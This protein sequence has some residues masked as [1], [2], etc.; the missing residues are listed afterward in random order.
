MS[1]SDVVI[2]GAGI[3]GVAAAD[4][5]AARGASV[6]LVDERAPLSL[7]S[8]KSTEC[9]RNWWPGPGNA[10]VALMNRSIDLIEALA[11]ATGNAFLLNRRGYLYVTAAPERVALLRQAGEEAA[12]LGA[13]PL[14]V[15]SSSASYAPHPAHGYHNQPDGAD[16]ILDHAT[17]RH[18]F[19]YLAEDTVAVLHARRCGWLSAQQLGMALLERGRSRGVRLA[20]ARVTAVEAT[21]G[22]VTAVTLDDGAQRVATGAFVNAAGPFLRLV[23]QMARIDLPVF[24]ERHRKVAFE[25]YLGAIPRDAPMIIC[26]DPQTLAWSADER[27]MLAED[28]EL[29]HLLGTLPAGVHCRPEGGTGS[30]W[31]LGLWAYDAAPV[32]ETFPLPPAPHF[33]DVVL[34]GLARMIPP[35]SAYT[36]R[37]PR[38]VLDGGYYTRTRENRP[39]IGPAGPRGSFVIGALSGYGIMAACG[40]AELLAAHIAGDALPPYAPACHPARYA[41]AAYRA[42]LDDWPDTGQL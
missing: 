19:P 16:L 21:G 9:Y 32:A 2:C 7:T 36:E 28:D 42:L 8:D 12:A 14:R 25:D 15:H 27:E 40:A 11:D 30:T 20:R 29:R 1:G 5:L 22:H 41:D 3:A 33:P 35:L 24:S 39:L 10:M 38:P 18:Y 13:G 26:A 17:I 37:P 31:V 23:G 4:A 6:L 34:R